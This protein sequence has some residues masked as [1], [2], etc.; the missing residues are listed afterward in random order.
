MF[1]LWGKTQRWSQKGKNGSIS[2][3]YRVGPGESLLVLHS[4]FQ[5]LTVVDKPFPW[6]WQCF[7]HIS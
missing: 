2:P 1:L 6:A 4:R 3:Q 5:P 7:Y